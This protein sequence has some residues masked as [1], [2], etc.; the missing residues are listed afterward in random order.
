MSAK[1]DDPIQSRGCREARESDRE[2]Q[3]I[4][5][6]IVPVYN[7]ERYLMRCLDSLLEQ[8][9]DFP[10]EIVCIDDKSPDGSSEIL[11][12]YA[13]VHAGKVNVF[14]NA[15]NLGLGRTR[16]KGVE[17]SS[18]EYVMFVDS[19]DFVRSD[20]LQTYYDAMHEQKCDVVVGGYITTDGTNEVKHHL[21]HS[22]W[23]NLSFSSSAGKLYRKS[24]LQEN[25]LEFT[26]V[27]YA[28]D[29]RMNLYAFA[30]GM[31]C[32]VIDYA[33][34]YYYQ[35]TA[36]ITHSTDPDRGYEVILSDFYREFIRS[37]AFDRLSEDE[38]RMVEY[39]Y[40][41]DMLNTILIYGNGCGRESMAKKRSYFLDQLEELFP[42]HMNSPYASLF[43]PKGQRRKTRVGV[44][45]FLLSRRFH[46][47]KLLFSHFA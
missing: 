15:E 24:F 17:L 32:F 39:S 14:H 28:E 3:V 25:G 19:D 2:T 6:V 33:G 36:S 7:V 44:S 8:T 13:R 4:I 20:Y 23:T 30:A 43:G 41:A 16:D 46:M 12:E 21:P 27:R 45:A 47:D 37:A 9:A 1:I 42:D 35:N 18:G 10:Y 5:S 31:R 11:K 40:I 26:G 38:K 22:Y 34:Y 29:T